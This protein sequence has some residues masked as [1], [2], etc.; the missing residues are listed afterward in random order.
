MKCEVPIVTSDVTCMPEVAGNA[1]ILVDPFSVEFYFEWYGAIT[2]Q[3][4][5]MSNYVQLGTERGL[6]VFFLGQLCQR[7][8]GV[9]LKMY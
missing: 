4:K 9:L 7:L 2:G 1:A 8:F 3:R 5:S 6:Y